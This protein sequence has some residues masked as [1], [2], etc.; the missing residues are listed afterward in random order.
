MLVL[1]Q[2]GESQ[3]VDRVLALLKADYEPTLEVE[4]EDNSR[5]VICLEAK[6]D[7]LLT[8]CGHYNLCYDCAQSLLNVLAP[9]KAQCPI[10]RGTVE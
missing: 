5:C 8:P 9:R 1:H 10:C 6:R 3:N 7:T 4:Q 2:R